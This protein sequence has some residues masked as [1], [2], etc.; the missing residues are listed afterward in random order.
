MNPTRYIAKQIYLIF[1]I[2]LI[3]SSCTRN[4]KIDVSNINVNV[5]IERFDHDF[6]AMH[7]KPMALQASY[8]QKQY[9]SFYP[10][11]IE[12]ILQ[13]GSTKDT[14]Y[15]KALR[16]VFAGKA[17]NDLKH[18][19]DAAFPNMDR[20]NASLTEA[21]KYIKYYYP[22]KP[23]PRVY[24]YISGFQAQTT[25]GDGYFGVGIDLFLGADSR[26]YPSLT[27]A[28]PHY[29]SRWFTPDNI[30][31]R[32]VEGI[33][34]EDMFPED[35]NDKALLNKMIYNGKIMYFMD[36]IL[37][38]VADSTKI[39]YSTEQL[40]WCHEFES[41]IWGYF[42]EQNL[43]YETDYQKIQKYLTEAPFTPGLGEKNESAPKLAVWT[44]WQ[45]VRKYMDKHPDVTL[46]QLM[47]D[48]DAQK[49]L[50]ESGYHPK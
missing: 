2:G 39:R 32:V 17:Y 24:A 16:Q 26:F 9:G 23:L 18:D 14:A 42:L 3:L 29:L 41:K 34:R 25:I 15:F 10:D 47:A 28:F 13:V 30:T 44:G 36:K 37:P 40:K 31:P 50:N 7:N 19:A 43:L 46:P 38:D 27:N 12:R 6:D 11:F 35:D 20:H 5:K 33:A 48:K 8:L 1:S 4:K 45:I 49:L 22:Q 21:F